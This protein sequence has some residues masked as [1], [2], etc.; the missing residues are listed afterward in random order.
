MAANNTDIADQA[1]GDFY[2]TPYD[3]EKIKPHC[4]DFVQFHSKDDDFV[5]FK[6]G[7]LNMKGLNGRLLE[8]NGLEHFG[9]NLTR[10]RDIFEEATGIQL[11]RPIA[12]DK[13][14][15]K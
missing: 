12:T 8:Y 15:I 5:P 14:S 13:E 10:M 1:M 7:E 2:D 4:D 11:P 3:F 9:N 6:A